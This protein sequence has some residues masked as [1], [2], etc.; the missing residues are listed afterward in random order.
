MES[1]L[2]SLNEG[3][4]LLMGLSL[5]SIGFAGRKPKVQFQDMR[6]LCLCWQGR[7]KEHEATG[8]LWECMI[9]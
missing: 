6:N 8:S 2:N 7:A 1:M 5:V 3:E 9:K 4:E